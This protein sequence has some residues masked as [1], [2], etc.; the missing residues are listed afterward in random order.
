[1]ATKE[2]LLYMMRTNQAV[3]KQLID[4]VT[5]EESTVRGAEKFNHIRWLVGHI[6]YSDNAALEMLGYKDEK[7]K[8]MA[9]LFG[10]GSEISNDSGVY[11]SMSEL[12]RRIYDFHEKG[13]AFVEG[14]SQA[15]LDK[16]TDAWGK[17]QPVW[18]LV[19]FLWMHEFYHAGQI[20]NVRK[21]LGRK[22]PF[23]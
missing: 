6:L 15:A 16:E 18:Q 13:I 7:Y 17:K 11:P 9:K 21:I 4:D 22:R 3:M 20:V 14:L 1:M 2:N 12:R 10:G 23:G 8:E 5:E 19:S